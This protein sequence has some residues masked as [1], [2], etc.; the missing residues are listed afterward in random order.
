MQIA[1]AIQPLNGQTQSEQKPAGEHAM[2]MMMADMFHTIA[3]LSIIETLIF[4]LP[5]ALGEL[6]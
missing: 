1:D 3:I 4:D 5:S 6:E 2:G